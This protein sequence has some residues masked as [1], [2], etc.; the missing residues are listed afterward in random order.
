MKATIKTHDEMIRE[1]ALLLR[2]MVCKAKR[3][4]RVLMLSSVRRKASLRVLSPMSV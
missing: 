4:T 1:E 2:R 3:R